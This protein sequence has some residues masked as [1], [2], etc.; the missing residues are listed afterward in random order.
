MLCFINNKNQKT[1]APSVILDEII[2]QSIETHQFNFFGSNI[3]SVE[4]FNQ[5]FGAVLER[6]PVYHQSKKQLLLQFIGLR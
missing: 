6:Y 4:Q 1:N 2:K 5:R 3:P